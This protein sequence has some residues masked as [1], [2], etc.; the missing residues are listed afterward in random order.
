M[1]KKLGLSHSFPS[2]YDIWQVLRGGPTN[3]LQFYTLT[4]PSNDIT[5]KYVFMCFSI[6]FFA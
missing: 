4:P 3:E 1:G 6:L 2:N 5:Q